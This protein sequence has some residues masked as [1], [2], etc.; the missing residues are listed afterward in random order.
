LIQAEDGPIAVD[1]RLEHLLHLPTHLKHQIP[2]VLR[3][4]DPVR[5]Q[6]SPGWLGSAGKAHLPVFGC[7]RAPCLRACFPAAILSKSSM[8]THLGYPGWHTPVTRR[9]CFYRFVL[10]TGSLHTD[11]HSAWVLWPCIVPRSW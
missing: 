5:A 4:V 1:E 6:E 11:H 8:R 9:F 3:L 2:A 10:D 7:G